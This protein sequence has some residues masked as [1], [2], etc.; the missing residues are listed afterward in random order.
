MAKQHNTDAEILSN[1]IGICYDDAISLIEGNWE[2]S[3]VVH[4]LKQHLRTPAQK[5][6]LNDF[7]YSI[8]DMMNGR[9]EIQ[10]ISMIN[11]IFDDW[12]S[13]MGIRFYVNY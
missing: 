4:F 7:D 5:K 8:E 1:N 13:R 12:N 2:E 10:D 11:A 6:I 9:I 3:E